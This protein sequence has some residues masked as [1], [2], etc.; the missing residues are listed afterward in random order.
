MLARTALAALLGLS[1]VGCLGSGRSPLSTFE[2]RDAGP[3]EDAALD[4]GADDAG[5]AGDAGDVDAGECP[6]GW[7]VCEG[8]CVDLRFDP[9]HCG[10]CAS[11]CV[12]GLVCADG[13]CARECGPGTALC[14]DRCADLSTDPAHCGGCDVA[15]AEGELCSEGA[16]GDRCSGGTI[17]CGDV[18]VDPRF[19]PGNCGACGNL[20]PEGTTCTDGECAPSCGPGLALCGDACVDPRTNP[21][22]CGRCDA[23]CAEEETCT[24]GRCEVVCA[25]VTEPCDGECVDTRFDPAHCGGCAVACGPGDVC[26]DGACV[27][28]CGDLLECD[29]RC[30]DSRVDPANCGGCGVACD[31]VREACNMGVCSS[32]CGVG[33]VFCG[34]RCVDTE[35]DP[36][37]CGDCGVACPSGNV[38]RD[39]RCTL[40]CAGGTVRCGDACVDIRSNPDHCGGCGVR[41]G[42]SEACIGG[43]CGMRPIEDRDGDTIADF[44]ETSFT[45]V[46]T[47]MDGTP[48]FRDLDSDG[49]GIDDADEAGDADV[50]SPPVDSDGDGIADFRDLDSD[51][52][53][54]DDA[55]ERT[56]GT[57]PTVRDTDGDG[58]TDALEVAG[59]TDPL[60]PR[61]CILCSGG[62][63]FELPFEATPRTRTLTFQP[64]L[65]KADVLFLV[66][67]TGSMSGTIDGL[68]TSLSSL[69][70]SI[71]AEIADTAFGV[72]RFDDFPIG[73]YGSAMCRGESDL[74]FTLE[75]RVTTVDA[76]VTAGVTALDTPLHCGGDAAESQIEAFYQAATGEGFRSPTGAVWTAPFDAMAGFDPDR[77]HGTVGGAGFRSDAL[78]IIIMATDQ[79]FHRRWSDVTPTAD[80]MT[81]CGATMAS[82][83]EPYA[84]SDF[85]AARDQ[86]PTAR[87]A[88]LTALNGIAAKVFGLAVGDTGSTDWRVELSSFAVGTGAYIPP[89]DSGNCSTGIGGASL[90]APT[91]DPDGPGPEPLQA[92]CPLV[93]STNR[94][95]TGVGAGVVGAIRD[96]TRFVS[97][98]T[99]H[100]EARNNPDTPGFDERRFFLRAVPVS[101]DPPAGC[102]LPRISDRLPMPAGDGVFDSFEDV[103]PGTD[104]TFQIIT[105]N[106]FVEPTCIDQIFTFRIVVIGDGITETDARTVAIR[107]PGDPDLC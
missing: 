103:C 88:A 81:W 2:A 63:V 22:H 67:T 15:C 24:A 84:M 30:V 89:D 58:E 100:V 17:R 14:G 73:T 87:Q 36:R 44:D 18:C 66:D 49:D 78:P 82:G 60:D 76:D 68:Q 6:A 59:G 90:P 105:E 62:F 99:V 35:I 53:G 85:G 102:D 26:R 94:D 107:V 61:D 101:A 31:P 83:C 45:R 29:G 38:C 56:L 27:A 74:P 25:G 98:T 92:L 28:S 50:L 10:A 71:R 104:V 12:G 1:L 77:G 52:D 57:D 8:V 42:V 79:T 16:C 40:E 9:E 37:N 19:D 65:Q 72:A 64:R 21:A 41:C 93:F 5:D 55:T 86:R 95:G 96:L 23:A 4:G 11:A 91:Y 33:T 32:A 97:F 3:E 51:N 47:D 106:D 48:D 70:A 75:Q 43:G 34:D 7:V 20:C 39:G 54:L 46:D 80:R 13:V 69:V